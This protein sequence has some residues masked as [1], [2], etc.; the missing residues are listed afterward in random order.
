M[1]MNRTTSLVIAMVALVSAARSVTAD[2][3][4]AVLD[5]HGGTFGIGVIDAAPD[6]AG[7]DQIWTTS[8]REDIKA[9][10]AFAWQTNWDGLEITVHPA[11]VGQ[12]INSA[13][14]DGRDPNEDVL[15]VVVGVFVHTPTSG[16]DDGTWEADYSKGPGTID[17]MLNGTPETTDDVVLTNPDSYDFVRVIL[18]P[19]SG[20]FTTTYQVT[21][22]T[23]TV[24]RGVTLFVENGQTQISIALGVINYP[25]GSSSTDSWKDVQVRASAEG[26]GQI[27]GTCLGFGAATKPLEDDVL[28]PL[29]VTGGGAVKARDGEP[30][31]PSNP[32]DYVS[33][34]K[35]NDKVTVAAKIT[36]N[37]QDVTAGKAV[38]WSE[39]GDPV[40][41]DLNKKTISTA[42]A[43]SKL[44]KATYRNS[45]QVVRINVVGLTTKPTFTNLWWL[46]NNRTDL[47]N[48]KAWMTFELSCSDLPAVMEN[49]NVEWTIQQTDSTKNHAHLVD[50]SGAPMAKT[51][52]AKW[53]LDAG[54]AGYKA[55]VAVDQDPTPAEG[56]TVRV[57]FV[58]VE[59]DTF[60][61]HVRTVGQMTVVGVGNVQASGIGYKRQ[62]KYKFVDDVGQNLPAH[63]PWHDSFG[64]ANITWQP[65]AQVTIWTTAFDAI[66]TGFTSTDQGTQI[67]AKWL[68]MENGQAV[69]VPVNPNAPGWNTSVI[70][71]THNIRIGSQTQ[72]EGVLRTASTEWCRGTVSDQ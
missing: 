67:I 21:L 63:L 27:Q 56:F 22:S 36:K 20:G 26:D 37:G 29:V 66:Q 50:S 68:V 7:Q 6:Q 12:R 8:T 1:T 72:G 35:A 45:V 65:P 33:P 11:N 64:N 58:G 62:Y 32:P 61:V 25:D 15:Y 51:F 14:A 39:A 24:D 17:L 40:Q 57:K 38:E 19:P 54:V 55:K 18:T 42:Q 5:Q 23:S 28:E 59:I 47:T 43:W 46:N 2:E 10:Y 13:T 4:D 30:S 34:K 69:P 31:N 44:L 53:K 41:G 49:L 48:F 3:P 70:T 16:G 71:Y 9:T 60:S 52:T